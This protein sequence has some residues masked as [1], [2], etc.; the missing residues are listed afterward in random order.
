M[1]YC[2]D[3]LVPR[4]VLVGGLYESFVSWGGAQYSQEP[5][6]FGFEGKVVFK[7]Q[8]IPPHIKK[9]LCSYLDVSDWECLSLQGEALALW[10]EVVN[11]NSKME[12]PLRNFL[13]NYLSILDDWA[14]VCELNCDEIDGVYKLGVDEVV[15]KMDE[16]LC[17]KQEPEGFIAWMG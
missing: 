13:L 15:K 16:I 6:V 17:W 4:V 12:V 8:P 10:E 3:I 9:L 2:F 11:D 1:E 14:L 5:R 7:Q